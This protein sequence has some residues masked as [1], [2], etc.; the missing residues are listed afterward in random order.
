MVLHAPRAR[1]VVT[2]HALTASQAP[3]LALV[4]L[5][6]PHRAELAMFGSYVCCACAVHGLSVFI[7]CD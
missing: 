4:Q 3:A 2:A 5:D 1:V 6:G 7:A